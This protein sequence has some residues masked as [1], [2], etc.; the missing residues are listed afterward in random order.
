[1]TRTLS[2]VVFSY[3]RGRVQSA[4]VNEVTWPEDPEQQPD[5]EIDHEEFLEV[6]QYNIF[7]ER[8]GV[9]HCTMRFEGI[10]YYPGLETYYPC[11]KQVRM[12]DYVDGKLLVERESKIQGRPQKRFISVYTWGP[13]GLI[14]RRGVSIRNG[15]WDA[16]ATYP[17]PLG[18]FDKEGDCQVDWPPP[19]RSTPPDPVSNGHCDPED[20]YSP[21]TGGFVPAQQDV[22]QDYTYMADHMGNVT[23]LVDSATGTAKRQVFDAF[24]VNIGGFITF[25]CALDHDYTDMP[26]HQ[27]CRHWGCWPWLGSEWGNGWCENGGGIDLVGEDPGCP[28]PPERQAQP[29]E[30]MQTGSFN[31]RGGEGSITDLAA[32]DM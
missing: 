4:A 16:E 10:H 25:Q 28:I 7:G 30:R 19:P 5:W 8:V 12:F 9:L 26:W 22:M 13:L 32:Q 27:D 31:W 11:W 6:Y 17:G 23:G 2:W 21:M 24:G 1:M 14:A 15:Y 29:V 3:D 18:Y 20:I